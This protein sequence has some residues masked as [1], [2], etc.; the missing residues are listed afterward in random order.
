MPRGD[1]TGPWWR[2]SG[3]YG[4]S[5]RLNPWCRGM[6]SGRGFWQSRVF[7]PCYDFLRQT[8]PDE[9]RSCL[10][11]AARL[12]ESDLKTIRDRLEKLRGP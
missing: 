5:G 2:G 9:E 1:G 6:R 4:S 12:L 11:E 10:E 7:A 8:T 3:G